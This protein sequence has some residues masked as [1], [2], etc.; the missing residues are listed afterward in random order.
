MMH[1]LR[2]NIA[3]TEYQI[4]TNSLRHILWLKKNYK[5]FLSLSESKPD[6]QII[7]KIDKKWKRDPRLFSPSKSIWHKCRFSTKTRF[8]DMEI[9]FKQSKA[10]V[11][12]APGLGPVDLVRF[13]CAIMLIRK[14]GFFLHASAVLDG[15]SSF[16]FFGPSESGKT[17]IARLSKDKT[18][19]TDE[20]TAL[21]RCNGSYN[22]YATPFAGDFGRVKENTSGPIKA[23]F[24]IKKAA[25]FGRKKIKAND[26]VKQLFCNAIMP[27][28]GPEISYYL[29]NT[30]EQ[31][32]RRV[33]CYELYFKAEPE[34]W[35]YIHGFVK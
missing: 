24:L 6:L 30:F 32:V 21:A 15:K 3:N 9:D 27:I 28:D 1:S 25:R 11:S 7:L 2:L 5:T 31:F 19:L 17:T 16:I 18:V 26:A 34:I 10:K 13:S 35:R 4:F 20:T 8:F 33:P 23:I 22:A 14:E 29:F 12:A